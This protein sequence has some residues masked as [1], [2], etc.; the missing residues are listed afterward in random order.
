[1]SEYKG[2]PVI[3]GFQLYQKICRIMVRPEGFEPP[4]FWFVAKHSIQLSYGRIYHMCLVYHKMIYASS[5]K[6]P[7]FVI[8]KLTPLLF[9]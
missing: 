6:K 8:F 7:E 3:L 9:F 2:I 1:M 5:V 4:T